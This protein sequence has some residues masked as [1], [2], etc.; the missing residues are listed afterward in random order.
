VRKIARFD[1]GGSR[2]ATQGKGLVASDLERRVVASLE[3]RG[4][5]LARMK[6]ARPLPQS[7]DL[8]PA[9]LPSKIPPMPAAPCSK[10]A[11]LS[12]RDRR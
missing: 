8:P 10:S 12:I 4:R 5:A 3:P 7:A 6:L 1:P 11:L 9:S 2:D